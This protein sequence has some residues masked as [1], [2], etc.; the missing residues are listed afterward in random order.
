L[1]FQSIFSAKGR[2]FLGN[3]SSSLFLYYNYTQ[4]GHK[5]G[6]PGSYTGYIAF[7]A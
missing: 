7:L 4:R 5:L 2:G 3:Y 1:Y 6:F